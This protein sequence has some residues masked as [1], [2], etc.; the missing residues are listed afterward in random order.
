[1]NRWQFG[2][3]PAVAHGK[4]MIRN[5]EKNTGRGLPDWVRLLATCGHSDEREQLVWLKQT[6]GL[7]K[8]TAQVVVDHAAQRLDAYDETSY[9]ASAEGHVAQ[10]FAGP[11]AA[12]R[13][14]YEQLMDLAYALG[15]DVRACPCK[16]MVPLYRHHVFAEIKPTT[17]TRIDLGLALRPYAGA[18]PPRLLETPGLRDTNRITHRFAVSAAS[19]IDDELTHWL[20]VAYNDDAS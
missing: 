18:L 4:A 11:K 12:L 10:L 20:T 8:V 16:T 3:H 9:M 2:I 19:D 1:M 14:L 15:P 6:H 13:P 5:L 17:R 7:G